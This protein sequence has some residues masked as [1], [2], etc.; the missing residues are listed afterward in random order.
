MKERKEKKRLLPNF[1]ISS[2]RKQII[3]KE[4]AGIQVIGKRQSERS[5]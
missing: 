1:N 2:S 5:N 3:C 4:G